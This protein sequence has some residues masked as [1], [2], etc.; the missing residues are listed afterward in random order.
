MVSRATAYRYFPSQQSL[1]IEVQADATEPS[2][3]ALVDAAGSDVA[4]RVEVVTRALTR[5]FLADEALFRN[6]IRAAQDAWFAREDT[7]FPVREG[8]RMR[9]I[10]KALEPAVGQI[11]GRAFK[12]LRNALAVVIGVEPVMSLRDICG[13]GPKATE[14][15][16]VWTAAALLREAG[17]G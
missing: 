5:A 14:D 15:T 9:W 12:Q 1:L 8:R 16:L 6:Q 17:L 10:D 2:I 3:E 4:A 13:L 11:D 7:S